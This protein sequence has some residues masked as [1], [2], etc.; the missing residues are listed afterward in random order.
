M[1]TRKELETLMADTRLSADARVLGFLIASRSERGPAGLEA[2]ELED[3]LSADAGPHRRRQAIRQLERRGYLERTPGGRGH[4]DRYEFRVPPNDSLNMDR[5]PKSDTLKESVE[6]YTTTKHHPKQDR[7]PPNATLNGPH[8]R[9]KVVEVVSSTVE[10]LPPI[11]PMATE[12]LEQHAALLAGC[13]GALTDYLQAHVPEPKQQPYVQTVATWLN[14]FGFTWTTPS[15]A[16]V[17]AKE[18][19]GM[20]AAALNELSTQGEEEMKYKPGDPRNLKTKL[21]ILTKPLTR[22]G[23][24]K[25]RAGGGVAPQTYDYGEETS[26]EWDGKWTR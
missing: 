12:A 2:E 21:D 15:G 5:V 18:R 25:P 1:A 10:A 7:V 26:E 24:A 6:V 3:A 17:P 9:D 16:R 20:L 14:G 19:T 8:T 13:R 22:T 4:P 11:S 23:H